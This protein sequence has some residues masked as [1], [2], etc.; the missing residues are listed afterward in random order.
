MDEASVGALG[1]LLDGIHRAGVVI[2]DV[3]YG[4]VI[5][6][7]GK[8]YLCD[9]D[10]ARVYPRH[11]LRFLAERESERDRFNYVFGGHLRS[12]PAS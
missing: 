2:H 12:E 3:K 4:N 11:S 10:D 9:F 8:P 5:M 7:D 6:L 1:R